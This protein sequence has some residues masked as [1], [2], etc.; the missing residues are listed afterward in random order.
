MTLMLPLAPAS[1]DALL[2]EQRTTLAGIG[3]GFVALTV[4]LAGTN[5]KTARQRAAAILDRCLLFLVVVVVVAGWRCLQN[6]VR[7]ERTAR[8]RAAAMEA[9]AAEERK[10]EETHPWL[11]AANKS[12]SPAMQVCPDVLVRDESSGKF[13]L[14][15][16][17]H[18]DFSPQVFLSLAEYMSFWREAKRLGNP[19]PAAFLSSTTSPTAASAYHEVAL[20]EELRRAEAM[21]LMR[22]S[23]RFAFYYPTE[24]Q[25]A[26]EV[27]TRGDVAGA[28]PSGRPMALSALDNN[29]RQGRWTESDELRQRSM[30]GGYDVSEAT[31]ARGGVGAGVPAVS[32]NPMDPNWGGPEYTRLLLDEGYFRSAAAAQ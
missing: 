23:S 6:L 32:A 15:N 21:E 14:Y 22:D 7:E 3:L 11:A 26:R 9:F 30:I 12:A 4:C 19:C 1:Y 16:R 20:E 29:Q 27:D 24:T 25:E 8:E 17:A 18:P 10:T 31:A 2:C 5:T 28:D 13:F